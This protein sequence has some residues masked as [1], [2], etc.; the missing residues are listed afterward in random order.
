MSRVADLVAA[1]PWAMTETYVRGILE[2]AERAPGPAVEQLRADFQALQARPGKPLRNTAGVTLRG[3]T[4]ILGI[5]GPLFRYANLF[6]E[7]SG[8]SSIERLSA[9]FTAAIDDPKVARVILEIDSPGGQVNGIAE[10]GALIRDAQARKPVIAY[11]SDSAASA[12]YWLAAAAG[13]IY[14]APTATL[15]SIGVVA[16]WRGKDEGA[17]EIVSSQ[18]PKKR[19]DPSTDEGRQAMQVQVDR[20][21]EEFIGAVAAYRGIDT[22]TVLADFGQGG[23]LVG[24]DA[25]AAGMADEVTTLERLLTGLAA[26]GRPGSSRTLAAAAVPL[27]E[28][29]NMSGTAPTTP[30]AAPA[31]A[32][33]PAILTIDAL[34]AAYPDLCAALAAEVS[35][36][37]AAAER[38]RV[39]GI[40]A[41]GVAMKG[42]DDLVAAAVADGKTTPDQLAGQLIAAEG[43]R[44]NKV[45]DNLKVDGGQGPKPAPSALGTLPAAAAAPANTPEAWAAEYKASADLQAEFPTEQDYVALRRAETAGGVRV[46]GAAR[47]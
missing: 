32:T 3:D 33:P 45:L 13:R 20:I 4:A 30:G 46:L 8:A 43:T 5:T 19:L 31:P 11:V 21:A 36:T 27:L 24:A 14:T 23:V 18:S 9:D 40:Q 28:N 37:A 26:A 29:S 12:A 44:R 6:T 22:S 15:G 38:T 2:I 34:R 16:I 17:T 7:M 41:H 35:T 47:K 10:F 25:V 39:L 1:M 42:H